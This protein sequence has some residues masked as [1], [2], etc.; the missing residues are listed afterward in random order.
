MKRSHQYLLAAALL[1]AASPASAQYYAQGSSYAPQPLYPY[2]VPGQTYGYPQ[3]APQYAPRA[4]PY[5]KPKAVRAR[6]DAKVMDVE[7]DDRDA[8]P[9]RKTK[10]VDPVLV[11]E[12]RARGRRGHNKS[13]DK[14]ADGKKI[15]KVITVRGKPRVVTT[16]RVVDDPPTVV[17][18]NYVVDVP[19]GARE[20][21]VGGRGLLRGK[22]HGGRNGPRAQVGGDEGPRV[23]RAEAEVHILGPDRMSIKLFR[24][25]TSAPADVPGY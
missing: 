20:E 4:Y 13:N 18:R 22:V 10:R 12:L 25:G 11:E 5:V 15:D 3:A 7:Q 6:A 17:T 16:Q 14:Y 24:R 8:A 19:P 23:I 2:A 1:I 21:P 9:A